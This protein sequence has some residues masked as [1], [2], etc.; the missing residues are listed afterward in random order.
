[1]DIR[2]LSLAWDICSFDEEYGVCSL[3]HTCPHTLRQFSVV[4][5]QPL[6]PDSFVWSLCNVPIFEHITS[7][8]VEDCICLLLGWGWDW[9]VFLRIAVH[10]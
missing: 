5:C 9:Y 1:M 7:E 10:M 4:I 6:D 8:C 2:D 3:G